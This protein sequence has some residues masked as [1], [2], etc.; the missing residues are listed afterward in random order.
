MAGEGNKAMTIPEPT[1]TNGSPAT[2][3]IQYHAIDKPS[4]ANRLNA[5]LV[6]L[7]NWKTR[8]AVNHLSHKLKTDPDYRQAWHAN[9]AMPVFDEYEK[10]SVYNH[11]INMDYANRTADRLLRHLFG[12]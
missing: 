7:W 1:S 10:I 5:W 6:N 9:L 4:R 3:S 12:V 11:Q 8:L 2:V